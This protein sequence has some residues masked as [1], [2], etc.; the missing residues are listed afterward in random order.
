MK[1]HTYM[2]KYLALIMVVLV[3]IST[4]TNAHNTKK[5]L[6]YGTGLILAAAGTATLLSN[7]VNK[8][9]HKRLIIA[10]SLYFAALMARIYGVYQRTSN[11]P[12]GSATSTAT[13]AHTPKQP[14]GPSEP[15]DLDGPN[16]PPDDFLNFDDFLSGNLT[17]T[18]E[19]GN[20]CTEVAGMKK[21]RFALYYLFKDN[22]DRLKLVQE[23]GQARKK[24]QEL[25]AKI[26][27]QQ[28]LGARF[29][30]SASYNQIACL[31]KEILDKTA[32]LKQLMEEAATDNAKK[33]HTH[34]ALQL[35]DPMNQVSAILEEQQKFIDAGSKK[36]Q[37]QVNAS[38]ARI[39]ALYNANKTNL[40][41]MRLLTST[42]SREDIKT[43]AKTAATI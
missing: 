32:E 8:A 7:Q 2:R 11:S 20:E 12:H 31:H 36:D 6:E 37:N 43:I 34:L 35:L 19:N 13:D 29:D 21:G 4:P 16:G 40:I 25:Y 42:G 38:K 22:S 27:Q 17:R 39:K 5:Y 24:I 18:D 3:S 41:F 33:P 14:S 9:N 10:A 30:P 28:N 15:N 23:M 1:D 26:T